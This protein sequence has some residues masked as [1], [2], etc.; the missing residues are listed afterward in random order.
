[1][2][3][4]RVFMGLHSGRYVDIHQNVVRPILLKLVDIRLNPVGELGVVALVNG[5]VVHIPAGQILGQDIKKDVVLIL[6]N[7]LMDAPLHE[8]AGGDG[9][10]W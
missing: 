5:G 3:G 7:G 2:R 6:H 9:L 8:G 4:L 1:M 10:T